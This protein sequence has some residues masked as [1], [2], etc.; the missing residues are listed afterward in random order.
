MTT[1]INAAALDLVR[2]VLAEYIDISNI[3]VGGATELTAIGVDSLTL[4]EMLFAMEDRVGQHVPEPAQVPQ[5]IGDLVAMIEP[6]VEAVAPQA[7]A[8]A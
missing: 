5:T 1:A 6:Y 7:A 8:T 4:A 3:H 2:E